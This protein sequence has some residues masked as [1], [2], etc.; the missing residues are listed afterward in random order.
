V[1][2]DIVRCTKRNMIFWS[3]ILHT[4]VNLT[5]QWL[6]SCRFLN[7][8][9]LNNR[10]IHFTACQYTEENFVPRYAFNSWF[11]VLTNPII[12]HICL[13]FF[14]TLYK[15]TF[16]C[17]SL[18]FLF[19]NLYNGILLLHLDPGSECDATFHLQSKR[20]SLHISGICIIAA[21]TKGNIL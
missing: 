13:Y 1:C 8:V 20:T 7:R 3:Y 16:P 12:C 21:Y 4:Y 19:C 9:F 6:F 18:I 15:K 5:S 14:R 17:I 11:H 10:N 2:I